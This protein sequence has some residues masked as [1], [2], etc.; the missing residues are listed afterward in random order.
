MQSGF[1]CKMCIWRDANGKDNK[2]SMQR[3]LILK[4]YTNS[5]TFFFESFYGASKK[6]LYAVLSHFIMNK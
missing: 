4:Q 5:F 6:K 3:L 1:I 2:I